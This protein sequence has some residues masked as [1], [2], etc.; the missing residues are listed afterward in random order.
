MACG[1]DLAFG[2]TGGFGGGAA[3]L[4]HHRASIVARTVSLLLAW[5]ERSRQRRALSELD[6]R[7]L[8]DIGL[9]RDEARREAM[10]SFWRAGADG[11]ID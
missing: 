4:H 3:T 1:N 5:L 8:R 11:V 2:R 9:T 10:R 6:D 7:L